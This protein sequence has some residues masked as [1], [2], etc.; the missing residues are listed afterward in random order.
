MNQT[1]EKIIVSRDCDAYLIP[2]GTKVSVPKDSEVVITQALGGAYT[3]NVYGNLVRVD[4]ADAD[5][6]GKEV[7]LPEPLEVPADGSVN[8]DA[9]WQQISSCYDPEIPVNIVELG[10]VYDCKVTPEGEG[11]N[12][13]DIQMTLTAPGCGMGTVIADE[14][15]RKVEAVPNVSE[16]YVE[17]VFDPPWNQNM[18]TEAAKLQLGML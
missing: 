12:R 1:Q 7:V 5:A 17:L 16:V 9:I 10:L 3:L 2:S 11:L 13:V 4:A 18:M 6:L 15:K 14:V 8:E